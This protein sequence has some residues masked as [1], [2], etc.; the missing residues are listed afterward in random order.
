MLHDQMDLDGVRFMPSCEVARVKK[1][2]DSIGVTF[3]DGTS[4]TFDLLL[5][6]IGRR[7]NT[8]GL[9]LEKAGVDYTERGVNVSDSLQSTNSAIY[10]CGDCVPGL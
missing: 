1:A 3:S 8:D 7:A 9:G 10:A 5:F 6:A 4:K 2:G